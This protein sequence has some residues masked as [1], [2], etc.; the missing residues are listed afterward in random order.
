MD[1]L[2]AQALSTATAGDRV[3]INTWL[4]GRPANTAEAYAR[5]ATLFLA[6]TGKG[7]PATTLMDLQ[8]WAD[9][10]AEASEA[11]RAQRLNA[12]RSLL[13]FATRMGYIPLNPGVALKVAKPRSRKGEKI[14]VHTDVLRL[15][16]GETDLRRRVLLKLLYL[17]GLRA[18]EIGPTSWRDMRGS[19]KKGGALELQ[20]KGGKM[21]VVGISADLWRE[22]L[23][24]NPA[25]APDSPIVPGRDGGRLSRHA[26]FRSVKRAARR[27]G[28]NLAASPH[29]L[30]HSHAS[31]ALD[32]G[33]PVHVLREQLGHASLATT[34]EYL[35]VKPGATSSGYVKA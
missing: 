4:H 23:S 10:M 17:T 20:G 18:H 11:T 8:A 30:R 26:V 22:L 15:I 25:P 13:N 24:L 27:A 33:C 29:W 19:E 28:V 16:A 9:S 6:F 32:N 14:L 34:T 21:R 3:V 5:A 1:I 31:H 7:V 35:H 2:P 12:V